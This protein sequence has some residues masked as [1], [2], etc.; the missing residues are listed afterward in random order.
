MPL[1]TDAWARKGLNIVK[2]PRGFVLDALAKRVPQAHQAAPVPPARRGPAE[3]PAAR[4]EVGAATHPAVARLFSRSEESLHPRVGGPGFSLPDGAQLEVYR[5][6]SPSAVEQ[7]ARAHG[8]RC[9]YVDGALGNVVA[10]DPSVKAGVTLTFRGSNNVC[11]LGADGHV[12]GSIRFLSD[13]G[14]VVVTGGQEGR[15]LDV[16]ADLLAP[17]QRLFLGS[18]TSSEGLRV[19]IHGR[20]IAVVLGDDCMVSKEVWF[21]PSDTRPIVDLETLEVVNPDADIVVEQHVWI[22]EQALLCRGA[23]VR[24][25][26]VVT[27]HSVVLADVAHDIASVLT[28][29]P[30]RPLRTGVT[31]D[32]SRVTSSATAERAERVGEIIG[33]ATKAIPDANS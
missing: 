29:H 7:L 27:M 24:A 19:S 6:D 10:V 4:F 9:D 25:G 11:V 21:R 20:G 22:Q 18:G 16:R 8:V 13:D 3:E 5:L 17:S 23:H 26:S 32:R 14:R 33:W 1:D 28:G 12:R 15:R 2:D 30:A 31:W